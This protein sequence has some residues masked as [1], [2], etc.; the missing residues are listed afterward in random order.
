MKGIP[1]IFGIVYLAFFLSVFLCHYEAEQIRYDFLETT[2]NESVKI[3]SKK[4]IDYS[5]RTSGTNARLDESKFK[6][7][8]EQ[9]FKEANNAYV[10]SPRINYQFFKDIKNNTIS[11]HVRLTDKENRVYNK[12]CVLDLN[13][14]R[15]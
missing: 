3:A 12:T 4:S 11:V 13:N 10:L 6:I 14:R 9:A 8:F 1:L 7:E 2:I 15:H 5:S